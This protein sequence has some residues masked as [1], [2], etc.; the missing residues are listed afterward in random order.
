[1]VK[2]ELVS[3]DSSLPY[4]NDDFTIIHGMI[5]VLYQQPDGEYVIVDYKT[6]KNL[7]ADKVMKENY[8]GQLSMYAQ[9][10]GQL[11]YEVAKCYVY[12]VRHHQ[13]FDV[14]VN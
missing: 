3:K 7:D 8:P 13:L 2:A 11:G 4:A 6:D 9:T 1:M 12:G 10:L 5:D 14:T